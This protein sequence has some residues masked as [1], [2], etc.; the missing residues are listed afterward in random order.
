MM[1]KTFGGLFAA[2][3]VACGVTAAQ[4]QVVI[5]NFETTPVAGTTAA[6]DGWV[7]VTDSGGDGMGDTTSILA[8]TTSASVTNKT[9]ARALTI[10]SGG[11]NFWAAR[12]DQSNRPGLAA[13]INA[14][15][16]IVADVFF[17]ANQWSDDANWGQWTKIAVQN[18]ATGWSETSDPTPVLD[19][20]KGNGDT[21]A[22]LTW[23]LA[24]VPDGDGASGA[25]ATL[26]LSINYARLSYD[27]DGATA[28]PA[29]PRF[30]LDNIRLVT[31]PEPA[32]AVLL[33]LGALGLV[34]RRRA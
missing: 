32:T 2:L 27:L 22:T 14:A 20:N 4:A 13:E 25:T 5:G 17:L 33:G 3:A 19:W 15:T 9:G 1:S 24:G 16:H 8:A 29:P 7:A 30:I 23:S 10:Q 6:L 31:V 21:P 18:T 26:I 34:R 28:A 12:L 11:H